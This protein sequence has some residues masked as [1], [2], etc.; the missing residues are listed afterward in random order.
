MVVPRVRILTIHMDDLTRPLPEA[1][2]GKVMVFSALRLA[3]AEISA[4]QAKSSVLR[5]TIRPPRCRAS[6][7][8][9]NA[10]NIV[11]ECS[12]SRGPRQSDLCWPG[13]MP[14][15]CVSLVARRLP[16][17]LLT[18]QSYL[19]SQTALPSGEARERQSFWIR[20]LR[21]RVQGRRRSVGERLE[22]SRPRRH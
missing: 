6:R 10:V 15:V 17:R 8:R 19:R 5:N 20:T 3:H 16:V 14:D 7:P 4:T 11:S 21:P 22:K 9:R 2:G 1:S 13:L 12:V 18:I